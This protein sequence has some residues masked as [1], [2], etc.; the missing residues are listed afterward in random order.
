M[1]HKLSKT[2]VLH[3]VKLFLRVGLFLVAF[4]SYIVCRINGG[5]IFS[6]YSDIMPWILAVIW[7]FYAVE[8]ALRFFPADIES[9]GCQKQFKKNFI[10]TDENVPVLQ[11]WQR[12]LIMALAWFG[13]NA[14][15]GILYFT[16]VIDAGMLILV[17]LAYGVGDMICIFFFF[18]P[19]QS[20]LMKNRCCTDCRIYNW[21]YAMMFTPYVFIP[22]PYTWSLLAMSLVILIRWEIT[23]RRH[24]ERFSERTNAGLACKNCT[25]KLCKRKKQLMSF[26]KNN[27]FIKK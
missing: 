14:I 4:I 16:G 12:T 24:P 20:W 21:D 17:S 22:H 19:F 11:S 5:C 6:E 23:Y 15:F 7:I 9:P 2:S 3:L 27:R 26:I 25:E 1:K 18:C 10:P 13:L 8:M